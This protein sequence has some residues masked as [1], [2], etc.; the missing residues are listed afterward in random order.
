MLIMSDILK[1]LEDMLEGFMIDAK[2]ARENGEPEAN[3]KIWEE[4]AARVERA[5]EVMKSK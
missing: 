4:A 2:T 3:A 5:I 1:I